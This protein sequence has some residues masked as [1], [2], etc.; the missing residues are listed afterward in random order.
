MKKEKWMHDVNQCKRRSLQKH[1]KILNS[2]GDKLIITLKEDGVTRKQQAEVIAVFPKYVLVI[3]DGKYKTSVMGTDLDS[4]KGGKVE[5]P[6][7][8]ER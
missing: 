2:V 5:W 4:C 7:V 1:P 6:K 8:M 3:I